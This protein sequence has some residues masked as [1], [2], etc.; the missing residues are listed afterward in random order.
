MVKHIVLWKLREDVD[1]QEAHT[2]LR[3]AFAV[4]ADSVQGM[5]SWSMSLSFDGYD[6]ALETVFQDREAL[7]RYIVQPEHVEYKKLP[8]QYR[9]DRVLCDY[10]F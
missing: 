8:E 1:R 7:D 9:T 6:I 2:V 4:L 5:E 3:D 10:E